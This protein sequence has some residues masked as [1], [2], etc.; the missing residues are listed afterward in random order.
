MV[1]FDGEPVCY[2]GRHFQHLTLFPQASTA[3]CFLA[4]LRV[5]CTYASRT[6]DPL[7]VQQIDGEPAWKSPYADLFAQAGFVLSYGGFGFWS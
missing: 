7:L 3:E 5:L 4:A 1:L 6:G 2:S